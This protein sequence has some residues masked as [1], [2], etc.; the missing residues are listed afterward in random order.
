MGKNINIAFNTLKNVT[1]ENIV[2]SLVNINGQHFKIEVVKLMT[3]QI[4]LKIQVCKL[5]NHLKLYLKK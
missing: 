2:I 3:T 4:L 5:V 1:Y